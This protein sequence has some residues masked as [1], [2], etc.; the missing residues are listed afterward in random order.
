MKPT[1]TFP[2]WTLESKKKVKK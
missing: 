2:Q 1:R